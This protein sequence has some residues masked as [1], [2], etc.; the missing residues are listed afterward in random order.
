L[1]I[2]IQIVAT[3]L[4]NLPQWR[5]SQT[6]LHWN[7]RLNN[8]ERKHF[9]RSKTRLLTVSTQ[10]ALRRWEGACVNWTVEMRILCG[11]SKV[12]RAEAKAEMGVYRHPSC[13]F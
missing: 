12:W 5:H 9:R 4:H 11:K 13:L 1:R 3:Q 8:L 7:M 6:K 10:K 2:G